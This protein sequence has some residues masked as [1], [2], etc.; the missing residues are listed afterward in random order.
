MK[1][2]RYQECNM[3]GKLWRRRF[4]LYIP[5]QVLYARIKHRKS[6]SKFDKSILWRT[7]EGEAQIK[8]K[9]TYTSAEVEEDTKAFFAEHKKKARDKK[10]KDLGI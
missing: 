2:K 7:Y 8:M 3:L 10:L 1:N 6:L 4:Y 9:W 5:F